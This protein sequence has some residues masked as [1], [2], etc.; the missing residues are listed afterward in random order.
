MSRPLS[1]PLIFTVALAGGPVLLGGS[2]AGA[3]A[4]RFELTPW[5]TTPHSLPRTSAAKPPGYTE[6][7]L[8]NFNSG[9]AIPQAGVIADKTGA[10]YGTTYYGGSG[11]SGSGTV[12]KLTPSGGKYT[13]SVLHSFVGGN[14]GA[15]PQAGLIFDSTGALYGTTTGGGTGKC[16]SGC[17]TVFALY[18][19]ASGAHGEYVYSFQAGKDGASPLAGLIDISGRLYGTTYGGGTGNLGTVFKLTPSGSTGY[20]ESVLYSFQGGK[21]GAGPWAGL[22]D[23]KG[24]LYGTTYYGGTGNCAGSVT[25]CGTVFRLTRSGNNYIESIVYSF[26]AGNDGAHPEA[27]LIF[28]NTGALYGTT[29][30]GGPKSDGTVFKLTP[31]GNGYAESVLYSFTGGSDG[32]NP[33]AGLIDVKGV[34]YGTTWKGGASGRG[35]V[36]KLTPFASGY[37][38]SVLHSFTDGIGDGAYPYAGLIDKKGVLYGTTEVG[39]AFNGGTVFELTPFSAS[40]YTESVLHSFCCGSDGRIIRPRA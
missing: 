33:Y 3:T 12:F 1:T 23:K 35:T 40:G 17:G 36:F 19:T 25:G 26:Q 16:F 38:E 37:A 21:D 18:P 31:A 14:D 15:N 5:S 20:T 39:G 11:P 9:G 13:E 34:L 32:G 2:R 10:L 4:V 29:A 7:V 24:A 30:S 22:I 27:G 6:S 28:D 8:F